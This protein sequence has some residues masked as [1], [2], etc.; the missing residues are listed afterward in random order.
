ME[1]VD[2]IGPVPAHTDGLG[3]AAERQADGQTESSEG[4]FVGLSRGGSM[5]RFTA[6]ASQV[7]E[8]G[9]FF[10]AAAALGAGL[11]HLR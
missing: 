6:V 8:L 9:V 2:V 5:A 7:A 3:K 11:L 10:A 1:G 4:A